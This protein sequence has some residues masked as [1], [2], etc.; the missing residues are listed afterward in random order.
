[1]WSSRANHP[2]VYALKADFFRVLGHPAR[3]RILQLLRDGER[4]V[5]ALQ[6]ALELDSSAVRP[7]IWRRCASRASWSAGREG[8]SVYYRVKRSAH[9]R[10]ARARQERSSPS[11][12]ERESGAAGRPRRRGL[13]PRPGSRLSVGVLGCGRARRAC[14]TLALGGLLAAMTGPAR[15][16]PG[17]PGGG[18]GGARRSWG[19]RCSIDG[20]QARRRRSAARSRRRFGLD[21]LSG[22]FL[23]V[24]ALTAVPTLVFARDYLPG[25]SGERGVGALTAGFLLALVG[26]LAARDVT[27]FLAF[28]ELMTLVPAAAIL[29]ARRD[30]TV[31]GA[32]YAYLGDHAPRRRRGLD[33]AA[34]A[35]STTA[36]SVTRRRSRP[37]AAAPRRWSRSRR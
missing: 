15:G 13:R 24:L 20:D 7:S 14:A 21:P 37:P 10:V 4:S 36:R 34:R 23:A 17:R 9:A 12:L 25:S 11:T 29:V 5:G 33:R 1:M 31:R 16:R 3:V 22:F 30:A 26:V 8:T 28:W 18:H 27:T 6:E 32:V 35:R 2:P 19:S